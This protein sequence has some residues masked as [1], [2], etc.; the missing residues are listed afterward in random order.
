[1]SGLLP[2]RGRLL[3]R[4]AAA[5]LIGLGAAL[6]AEQAEFDP[7]TYRRPAPL[8][9]SAWAEMAAELRLRQ[10]AARPW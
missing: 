1:M 3:V 7:E 2:S 8:D 5:R 9:G 6:V 10:A 4:R